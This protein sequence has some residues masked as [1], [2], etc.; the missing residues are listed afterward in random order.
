MDLETLNGRLDDVRELYSA[1]KENAESFPADGT[2]AYYYEGMAAQLAN[3]TSAAESAGTFYN[4]AVAAK[5]DAVAAKD[6]AVAAQTAAESAKTA[7]ESASGIAVDAK[8]AAASS[9]TSA[10]QSAAAAADTLAA[11]PKLNGNNTFS[12]TNTFNGRLAANG[13]ITGLPQPNSATDAISRDAVYM[14]DIYMQTR[15]VKAVPEL[16]KT[17][18]EGTVSGQS[19]TSKTAGL[20]AAEASNFDDKTFFPYGSY[21]TVAAGWVDLP[22]VNLSFG[23]AFRLALNLSATGSMAYQSDNL[24]IPA[25]NWRDFTRTGIHHYAYIEIT[26]QVHTEDDTGADVTLRGLNIDTASHTATGMREC[27]SIIPHDGTW[28]IT[29]VFNVQ[30]IIGVFFAFYSNKCR[31]FLVPDV[32]ATKPI[33]IGEVPARAMLYANYSRKLQIVADNADVICNEITLWRGSISDVSKGVLAATTASEL[34]TTDYTF[35][36]LEEIYPEA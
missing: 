17:S 7:A 36:E 33:F 10:A 12:G 28:P 27:R 14:A 3:A 11:A 31:V 20:T 2:P 30:G 23:S 5:N 18:G 15:S 21:H 25:L 16:Q 6:T 34:T 29:G 13:G 22:K 9:A 35:E 24:D 26:V 32:N 8:E 1:T 19:I 4:G